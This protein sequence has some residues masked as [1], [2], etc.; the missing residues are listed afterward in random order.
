MCINNF[1]QYIHVRNQVSPH[2]KAFESAMVEEFKTNSCIHEQLSYLSRS[3]TTHHWEMAGMQK[4][5]GKPKRPLCYSRVCKG[6]EIVG[7]VPFQ[8][9]V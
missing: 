7:H 2:V 3:L 4:R 1:H 8:H 9:C 6:N 5:I